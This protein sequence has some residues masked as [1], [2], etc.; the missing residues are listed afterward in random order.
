MKA[1]RGCIN[2]TAMTYQALVS[3][4]DH[5]K[6]CYDIA[7]ARTGN[8]QRFCL[9]NTD[10]LTQLLSL[11]CQQIEHEQISMIILQLLQAAVSAP[12]EENAKASKERKERD[13]S[14]ELENIG[15]ETKFDPANCSLLVQ[16]IFTQ[17]QLSNLALFV[18][19]FLLEAISVAVRWLAHGLI[20]SF[21]ENS[22]EANKNKLMDVLNG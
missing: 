2:S 11:S 20:Y 17:V 7:S 1:I 21:Y 12:S 18:K 14:E 6:S 19:T 15:S 3:L 5:L 16:Q 10:V 4:M 22:N 9:L 8:W 13:K